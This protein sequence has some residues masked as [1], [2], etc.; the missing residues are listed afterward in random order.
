MD[1][2]SKKYYDSN[3]RNI[4]S[5]YF[6]PNVEDETFLLQPKLFSKKKSETDSNPPKVV[7][8]NN[9]MYGNHYG[10]G[11]GFGNLDVN[12]LIRNGDSTRSSN[13][14][15]N[16]NIESSI[17]NRVDLINKNYQDP[18]HIILP[19]PRGGEIT[20]KSNNFLNE[21][22]KQYNFKY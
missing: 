9:A 1:E 18:N 5:S 8:K 4:K 20:R 15:F 12:N 6:N 21:E 3:E 19:F 7:K 11:K 16:K 22:P 17:N 13:D 14:N 10:P 2:K